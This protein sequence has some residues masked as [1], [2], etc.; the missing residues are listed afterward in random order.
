MAKV[1]GLLKVAKFAG[2]VLGGVATAAGI[3]EGAKIVGNGVTAGLDALRTRNAPPP[4]PPSNAP[5]PVAGAEELWTGA[6][7]TTIQ[8]KQGASQMWK[9]LVKA[10][11]TPTQPLTSAKLASLEADLKKAEDAVI[12]AQTTFN[13][14]AKD[15]LV[16]VTTTKTVGQ[17]GSAQGQTQVLETKAMKLSQVPKGGIV[18]TQAVVKA[19]LKKKQLQQDISRAQQRVTTQKQLVEAEKA[20]LLSKY[21]GQ[22]AQKA[23]QAQLAESKQKEATVAKQ[24]SE[25]SEELNKKASELEEAKKQA[26]TDSEKAQLEAKIAQLEAQAQNLAT[27]AAKPEE[28]LQA[29]EQPGE[30]GQVLASLLS[31]LLTK[32]APGEA[33][34]KVAEQIAD[35][36]VPAPEPQDEAME[37]GD[38][39][40]FV[41]GYEMIGG[42]CCDACASGHACEGDSC[43]VGKPCEAA[44]P[45]LAG[46]DG[47]A[48]PWAVHW[49]S[50]AAPAWAEGIFAGGPGIPSSVSRESCSTGSCR[51]P[52]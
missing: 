38:F 15:P 31:A 19:E 52:K 36:E 3:Y 24:L 43:P 41:S 39:D 40:E 21:Q 30:A 48:A 51:L 50:P 4:A 35:G 34:A 17:W 27:M 18:Y 45:V 28:T 33:P 46:D 47:G 12:A 8:K 20:F 26:E 25:T 22:Q 5:G 9:D 13:N 42:A 32:A 49:A 44:E 2:K 6:G 7:P 11:S 16:N 37:P 10:A 1:A 14:Y 23:T 29:A